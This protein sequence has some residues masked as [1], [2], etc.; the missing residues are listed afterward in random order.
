MTTIE[1]GGEA[2]VWVSRG[3]TKGRRVRAI[4]AAALVGVA[5]LAVGCSALRLGYG[6]AP[7]LAYYWIDGYVDV[8]DEQAPRVREAIE[9]WFEWHR[10]TQLA[11]YAALLAKAQREL[12]Q[13]VTAP[14]M[15][16]WRDEVLRRSDALLDQAA[17]QAAPLVP[18]LSTEQLRNIERRLARNGQKLRDELAPADRDERAKAVFKRNLERY[19][20][21]YGRLDDAQ[22]ERLRQLLAASPF[23][24]DR[25][26]AERDRRNRELLATLVQLSGSA[27]TRP[28]EPK[29]TQAALR[30][31]GERLL[32]SPRADYR[33]YQERLQLDNCEQAAVM[34]NLTTPAQRQAAREKLKGWEDDLRALAADGNGARNGAG[35][36]AGNGAA[37]AR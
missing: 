16:A 18:T 24:P 28:S 30:L 29:A 15:C 13:P 3:V 36:G 17:A 6:Q 20:N 35:N 21:L 1:S 26:F 14:Q 4:I 11:D 32:R 31:I 27:G 10:R 8:T 33:A 25:W 12:A 2:M 19:E 5:A 34:H 37:A 22:R 7:T 23:D 9:R